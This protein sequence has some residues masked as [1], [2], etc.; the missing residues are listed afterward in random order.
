MRDIFA[1]LIVLYLPPQ[2]DNHWLGCKPNVDLIGCYSDNYVLVRRLGPTSTVKY[3]YRGSAQQ[4]MHEP[5]A[6]FGTHIGE[7]LSRLA[8][9]TSPRFTPACSLRE[10]QLVVVRPRRQVTKSGRGA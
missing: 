1:N 4:N 9:I 3:D 2:F 5:R 6:L 10:E 8:L 7:E